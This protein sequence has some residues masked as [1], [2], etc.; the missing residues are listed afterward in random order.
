MR[1]QPFGR[2]LVLIALLLMAAVP[3]VVRAQEAESPAPTPTPTPAPTPAPEK[4]EVVYRDGFEIRSPN[5]A[6]QLR[7]GASLQ[8]DWRTFLDDSEAPNSFD[9]RRAR[10]DF[11]GRLREWIT[12][13]IQISLENEPYVRNAWFD[14]GWSEAFH[15]RAGQ[16]KVPFSTSWMT[17]DNQV[18]FVERATAAP[19]YPFFDR[20]LMA[21]GQVFDNTL[22]Y[23]LGAYNG[24]G[25]DLDTPRGDID[26]H[27]DVALRL[28]AQPFRGSDSK[29]LRGL[30]LV[31][32]GTYG[33][34]SVAT[35]RFESGGL[36]TAGFESR[37][38]RWRL[39]QVIGT[40]GRS[41]DSITADID[42]RSRWGVE[43]HWLNG[44]LTAS[45]EYLVLSYDGITITHEYF[46][47]SNRLLSDPQLE[48][49][50]DVRSASLWVSWFLTGEHKYV[51]AFGWRQPAPDSELKPGSGGTGAWELL[52]RLSTTTTDRNLFETVTVPG[53]TA[54]QLAALGGVAVGE[55][56]SVKAAV[57][58]GAAE[59]VEAT[60]GVNWTLN[61]NLRL[62]F[63]LIHLW[64][65][66][67]E[68]NGGLLSASNSDLGDIT[69]RNRKVDSQTSAILR[70]IFRF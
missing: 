31:G 55:G 60:L 27:K 43:A 8:L 15:L 53:Y 61:P 28:F 6:T 23:Q 11:R 38:W 64:V 32:E 19:V 69:A 37:I 10:I 36:T 29:A 12:Y 21:W 22:T 14:L 34:Q 51:D 68:T 63:N 44:P 52:A 1:S 56:E 49:S 57:F 17:F 2:P 42:S 5:G 25:I 13:R 35:K 47:G 3:S 62:Q 59:A 58:D 39:E 16:M 45:F 30:Y 50:G 54:E 40:D 18:N 67:P 70:A 9:I 4:L 66:D 46:Q 33:P 41:I 24:S 26:D 20:G 7:I 65:P 48:G